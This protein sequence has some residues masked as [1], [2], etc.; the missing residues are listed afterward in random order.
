[1]K[2]KVFVFACAATMWLSAIPAFGAE[3]IKVFVNNYEVV[4]QGQQP[5]IVDGYTLVPVR[6]ALEAMG[7]Q[8]NW[9]QKEK[10]VLLAKDGQEAKLVIGEK[11]FAGGAEKLE[12]PAQ[13]IGGSTMIP[14]RAAVEYFNGQISWNS[15]NKTVTITIDEKENPYSAIT[16]KKDLK[17]ADGKIIITGTVKYPQLNASV[18]GE[19]ANAI[20]EKI[21]EWAKGSLEAYLSEQKEIVTEEAEELGTDF[22]VHD[23][24]I[25]FETPYYDTSTFSFYSTQYIYMGGAHGSSFAKGFTYNLKTGN[26]KKLTDLVMLQN[27]MTED[28]YLKSII[29]ADINKDSTKYFEEAEKLLQ[30]PQTS[31]GFYVKGKDKLEVFISEAGTIAPYSSGIIRVEKSLK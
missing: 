10:S 1:M 22:K 23:F 31:L 2:K 14:L 26:E 24:E 20:N 17:T 21:S 7:V 19:K 6:G 11:Y 4:F 12:T 5:V 30:D 8:V 29:K 18:L 3:N 27:N 13:M 16:Y 25:T 15:K 9:N 28:T